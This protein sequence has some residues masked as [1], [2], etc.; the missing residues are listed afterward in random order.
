[1]QAM[2]NIDRPLFRGEGGELPGKLTA[3]GSD[4]EGD[5]AAKVGIAAQSLGQLRDILRRQVEGRAGD[6]DDLGEAADPG[7]GKLLRRAAHFVGGER[8]RATIVT[9]RWSGEIST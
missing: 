6:L 7:F 9:S 3:R 2:E 4:H 5:R 1:M 8:A